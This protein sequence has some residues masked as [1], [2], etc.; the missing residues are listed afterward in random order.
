MHTNWNIR[1]ELASV[2]RFISARRAGLAVRAATLSPR[3]DLPLS[4]VLSELAR[5]RGL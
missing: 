2:C 1:P 5:L 3:P 4:G